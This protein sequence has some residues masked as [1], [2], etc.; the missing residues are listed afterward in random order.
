[1]SN[2]R[3]AGMEKFVE[4]FEEMTP[5]ALAGPGVSSP[6][7]RTADSGTPVSARTLRERL[8]ERLDRDGRAL[9]APGSASP[10]ARR[11]GN[12]PSRRARSACWHCRR[13]RAR[14]PRPCGSGSHLSANRCRGSPPTGSDCVR[15]ARPEP[16]REGAPA[17]PRPPAEPRSAGG[18]AEASAPEGCTAT[19]ARPP[20]RTS[21]RTPSRPARA[22]PPE[23]PPCRRASRRSRDRR[24]PEET[25][26]RCRMTA[27]TAVPSEAPT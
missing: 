24:R 23:S 3:Q 4:P 14:R 19:T 26:W 12:G 2:P 22:P 6:T 10:R 17:Q 5:S 20:T 15:A 16:A 9:P 27:S 1:M 11:P 13:C 7:P 25:I 21:A 18:P 8:R